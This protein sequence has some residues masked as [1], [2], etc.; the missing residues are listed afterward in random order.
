MSRTRRRGLIAVL[1]IGC[2]VGLPTDADAAKRKKKK[3]ATTTSAFYDS[4]SEEFGGDVDSP[5]AAC[6]AN[7]TVRVFRDADPDV[8]IG[9]TTPDSGGEWSFGEQAADLVN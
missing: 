1:I 6:T 5:N 8:L 4:G 7:R 3:Y 9:T 2:L